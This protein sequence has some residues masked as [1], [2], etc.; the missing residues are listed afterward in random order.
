[1]D[2]V[3]KYAPIAARILLGLIFF[4]FGLNGFLHFLPQPPLP[5]AGGQFVGALIQTGYLF[6]LVKA[7]EVVAGA[8]LLAGRFVPLALVLLAPIIINIAG[9]HIFLVPG[10]GMVALL[11]ALEIFLAW[12]YRESFRP[13][14]QS[15]AT[16]SL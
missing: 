16:A 4:V 12:A 15:R 11:L 3:K 2:A 13:V 14:L 6:P 5:S 7:T 8:L 10:Y 9:F 1:M